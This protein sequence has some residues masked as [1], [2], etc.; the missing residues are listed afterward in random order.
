MI[1][2][3]CRAAAFLLAAAT[4]AACGNDPSA[5]GADPVDSAS[6][7]STASENARALREAALSSARV[8][9]PPSTPIAQANLRVNPAGPGHIADSAEITCRFMM[10]EVSGT[11]PKFY[12]ELP[13]GEALKIKYGKWNPELHAEVAATRLLTALGF[14]ADQMFIVSKVH[15]AGCPMFPFQALRCFARVGAHSA[16]FPG[17]ISYARVID[18]DWAVLERKLPGT[19]IESFDGQGWAWFELESIDSS[20]GGSTRAQL[21]AFRLMAVFLA[22]WDNKSPNQRLICPAGFDNPDGGC[23]QPLAIIQDLG[24]TFGPL[25][26]DLN[27]WK[28][29]RIWKDG[30]TCT[31]SME[32]LPWGGGTFPERR[33]SE[34]GRR[35]L[36]ELLGQLSDQQVRDLFEGSRVTAHEQLGADARRAD[37][38]L[39]AFKDRVAQIRGAGPCSS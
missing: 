3:L 22:H 25:K 18:F 10:R 1:L 12:C 39:S 37:A 5:T 28:R 7:S 30:A 34:A 16:C 8:W 35:M 26:I 17:G 29:G 2:Q 6:A 19:V 36:L 21:D 14:G 31:V 33:I 9:Q 20:R 38:W 24:A 4:V 13:N 32:S 23:R 11:T 15:C 27:N